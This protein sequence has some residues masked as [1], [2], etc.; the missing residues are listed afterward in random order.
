MVE[1]VGKRS[2][3]WLPKLKIPPELRDT[4]SDEGGGAPRGLSLI[5]CQVPSG[6]CS[7]PS[8]EG[9]LPGSPASGKAGNV[10]LSVQNRWAGRA[11]SWQGQGVAGVARHSGVSPASWPCCVPCS[12]RLGRGPLH[13]SLDELQM[14]GTLNRVHGAQDGEGKESLLL[15]L[16]DILGR[17]QGGMEGSV[18]MGLATSQIKGIPASASVRQAWGQEE[19]GRCPPAERSQPMTRGALSPASSCWSLLH[20]HR[21]REAGRPA[22]SPT[23]PS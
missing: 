13:D 14:S 8:S 20:A 18:G 23:W 5:S 9:S 11:M 7:R 10:R 6:G 1:C 17:R 4:Q 16:P 22:G 15:A 21:Q 2:P 3:V 19:E 12:R